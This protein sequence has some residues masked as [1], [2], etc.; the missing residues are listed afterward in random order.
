MSDSTALPAELELLLDEWFGAGAGNDWAE[1]T[2]PVP[3]PELSLDQDGGLGNWE[4]IGGA[5]DGDD[6]GGSES[7]QSSGAASPL[8]SATVVTCAT[9]PGEKDS[10]DEAREKNEQQSAKRLAQKTP[11]QLTRRKPVRDRAKAELQ[12]LRQRALELELL[13]ETL[14]GS[15]PRERTGDAGLDLRRAWKKVAERQLARRRQTE[16]ENERLKAMLAE[17]L[18]QVRGI[19]QFLY[20]RPRQEHLLLD[21]T[22]ESRLRRKKKQHT[23]GIDIDDVALLS[24][25]LAEEDEFFRLVDS[26]F[27][28]SRASST[29]TGSPLV[30]TK[31]TSDGKQALYLEFRGTSIIPFAFERIV[32]AAWAS[33]KCRYECEEHVSYDVDDRPDDTIAVRFPAHFRGRQ[34]LADNIMAIRRYVSNDRMVWVWRALFECVDELKHVVNDETGWS[35]YQAMPSSDGTASTATLVR[36]C[37]RVVPLARGSREPI[38]LTCEERSGLS[39]LLADAYTDD[40]DAL[41]AMMENLLLDD[42]IGF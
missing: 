27:S 30:S 23:F 2:P 10:E 37:S 16:S 1:L 20:K 39:R 9:V 24:R 22:N 29:E 4:Q 40:G 13:L 26:I 42:P 41:N 17:F 34:V 38:D 7:L 18:A 31:T 8:S 25:F 32:P 36:S 21:D 19:K 12:Y 28:D 6:G 14:K 11:R 15:T 3:L 5:A 33:A 35:E